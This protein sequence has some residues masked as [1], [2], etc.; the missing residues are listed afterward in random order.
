[1]IYICESG[2][3]FDDELTADGN[4][5]DAQRTDYLRAHFEQARRAIGDGIPLRGYFVWTLM[6][7][8]EWAEGYNARFGVVYTDFESQQRI[9]KDSGRLL[10]S[11]SASR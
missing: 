1:V 10:R 11:Y 7:N 3:A 5:H 6:D 8:F 2:A 4:I 9:V